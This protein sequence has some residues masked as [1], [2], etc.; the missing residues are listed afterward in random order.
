MLLILCYNGEINARI[1][2]YHL[3]SGPPNNYQDKETNLKYQKK[4]IVIVMNIKKRTLKFIIDGEDKG[5]SYQ[6]IPLDK[7]L[8]P[9]VLLYSKDDSVEIMHVKNK[10]N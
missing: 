5:D 7:P 9:S 3:W 4:E 6:N 8:F 10:N 1:T 2:S